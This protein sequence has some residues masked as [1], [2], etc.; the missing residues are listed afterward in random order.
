LN[1]HPTEE[2]L[3]QYRH[4]AAGDASSAIRLHLEACAGCRRGLSAAR[5]FDQ[6]IRRGLKQEVAPEHLKM[7]IARSLAEESQDQQE[8]RRHLTR[9]LALGAAAAVFMVTAGLTGAWLLLG[10]ALTPA[11]DSTA[12]LSQDHQPMRGQLVCFGCARAHAD[13]QHQQ[14]CPPDGVEHVT[15]LRTPDGNL[16]RF[17]DGPAIRAFMADTAMRGSWLELNAMPYPGIGYLQ[18]ANARQL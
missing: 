6:R 12:L 7:R 4:G 17:V 16:W 18:I 3:L 2:E 9:R 15:G 11:L 10:S 13:I 14:H 8:R 5:R 1:S